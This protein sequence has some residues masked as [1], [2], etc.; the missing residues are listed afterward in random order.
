MPSGNSGKEIFKFVT[1]VMG[2]PDDS[3]EALMWDPQK[4]PYVEGFGKD[5][6]G[7]EL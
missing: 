3:C 1:E 6:D 5:L 7:L 2:D 4:D